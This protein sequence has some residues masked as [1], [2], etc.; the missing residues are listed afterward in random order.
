[1]SQSDLERAKTKVIVGR[2]GAVY[3][4]KGWVKIQSFTEPRQNLFSYAPLYIKHQGIWQI[5]KLA[6]Y[7]EQAKQL[8]AQFSGYNDRESAQL[9]TGSE[10][11]IERQQLP[12]L[13]KN[14][15]YWSDLE[16]LTVIN[17]EGVL[18][19]KVEY[20]FETGSNDVLVV[21][22]ERQYL[23]P[24]LL[25]QFILSVDLLHKNLQVDWDAEF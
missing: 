15:Y 18:L 24:F 2:V 16:G 22:G 9:L 20:I 7:N 13:A 14:E 17:T 6:D 12:K 1:M 25:N 8:V 23:I 5:V 19:G 4:I 11:A 10:L 3:G 21:K